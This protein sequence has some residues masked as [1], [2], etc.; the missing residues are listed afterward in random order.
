MY[1]NLIVICLFLAVATSNLFLTPA[2]PPTAHQNQFYSTRFRVRGLD[3]PV[4]TFEGLPKNLNGNNNGVLSGVPLIPGA[5]SIVVKYRSG[6]SSGSR[7]VI[8]RVL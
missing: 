3:N 5:F 2:N 7:E 4:F 8:L 1:K 6:A